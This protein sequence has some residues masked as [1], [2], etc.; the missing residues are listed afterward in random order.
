MSRLRMRD[1]S[2]TLCGGPA[3]GGSSEKRDRDQLQSLWDRRER[4]LQEHQSKPG[5]KVELCPCGPCA[6]LDTRPPGARR[7]RCWI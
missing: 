4:T 5:G 1:C 2:R 6:L 7:H 3:E